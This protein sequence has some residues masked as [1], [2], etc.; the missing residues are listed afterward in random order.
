MEGAVR[1]FAVVPEKVMDS[2][3]TT[4]D[5][6]GQVQTHLISFLSIAEPEVLAQMQPLQRAQSMLLLA[7]VTTTLFACKV[8]LITYTS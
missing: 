7:R 3:K 6:V 8:S 4:L 1:D 5:N 2:V